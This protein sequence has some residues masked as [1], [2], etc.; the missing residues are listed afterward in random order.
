MAECVEL[1]LGRPVLACGA[2]VIVGVARFSEFVVNVY[3]ICR[4]ERARAILAGGFSVRDI[5][6]LPDGRSGIRF[7]AHPRDHPRPRNSARDPVGKDV[8]RWRYFPPSPMHGPVGVTAVE[9]EFPEPL[10]EAWRFLA[11]TRLLHRRTA[12]LRKTELAQWNGEWLVP[13][14]AVRSVTVS[15]PPHQLDEATIT[16]ILGA[17]RLSL[18]GRLATPDE[19]E[20]LFPALEAELR[21]EARHPLGTDLVPMA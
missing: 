10:A 21:E 2:S 8:N 3:H 14:E 12:Q 11:P 9:V 16:G 7:I 19:R 15:P 20:Q 1:T 4:L 5:I 17:L 13:L 6:Y 18:K